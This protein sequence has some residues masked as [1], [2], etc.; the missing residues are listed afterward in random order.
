MTQKFVD[1]ISVR[2]MSPCVPQIFIA[3]LF[4]LKVLCFD[5]EVWRE[6]FQ[7]TKALFVVREKVS[8]SLLTLNIY[9]NKL[10]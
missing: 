4:M 10:T 7:V 5:A 2:G 8:K 6:G 1:S 9:A 3:L